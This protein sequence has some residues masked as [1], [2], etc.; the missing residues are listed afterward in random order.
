MME[1]VDFGMWEDKSRVGTSGFS[2]NRKR[3]CKS[4]LLFFTTA[5]KTNWKTTFL[6]LSKK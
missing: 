6:D 2:P 4:S 1:S 3:A 5:M